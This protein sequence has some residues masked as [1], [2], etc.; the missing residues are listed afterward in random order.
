MQ[1][2][3]AAQVQE[4]VQ[5]SKQAAA[6]SQ[7][8]HTLRIDLSS[9]ED[10]LYVGSLYLGTPSQPVKVIFDTGSEHLAVS[11]DLC[12]GCKSKAFTLAQSKTQQLLSQET[13]TVV[14]GSAKF[15]GK[16]TQDRTCI[17]K[18]E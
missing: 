4:D 18:D 11:S 8:E 3:E 10:S 16:E 6:A 15:E 13:K 5:Q 14:Y 12:S 1:E 9:N 17:G 7:G 2:N